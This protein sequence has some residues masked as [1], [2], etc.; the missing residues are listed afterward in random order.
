MK[1]AA[2]LLLSFASLAVAQTA[3]ELV[4]NGHFNRASTLI[5]Q[6]LK[7]NPKDAR[8]HYL[9][10]KVKQNAEDLDDAIKHVEEAVLLEPNN[11]E[12]HS[13]LSQVLGRKAQRAPVFKKFGLGKKCKSETERALQLDPAHLEANITLML[14][15]DQAPGF[16]GG[17]KERAKSMP[18]QLAKLDPAKGALLRAHF[19]YESHQPEKA[20]EHYRR[21]IELSP[22]DF[23]A[24]IRIAGLL[25]NGKPRR[26]EEAQKHASAAKQLRP[27]HIT[28]RSQLALIHAFNENYAEMEAEL[29]EAEK[30]VPDDLSPYWS[31]ARV[32]VD[33]GKELGRAETYIK[34]YLAARPEIGAPPH[35]LAHWQLGLVYEKL[36][37]KSDAIAQLEKSVALKRDFEP[38]QKDLKRLRG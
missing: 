18:D 26:L 17:D 15:L 30:V 6:R 13:Y 27:T 11:A 29:T 4:E 31:V 10:G 24:R 20:I 12:Y 5:E 3:D 36:G 14:F 7:S 8:A 25:I 19:E 16:V 9:L 2:T 21:A 33:N 38:A 22:K 23:H 1:R 34:K 35:A 28:P 32:L 37:R